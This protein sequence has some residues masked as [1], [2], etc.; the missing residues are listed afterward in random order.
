M[1]V[2]VL[3]GNGYCERISALDLRV[4]SRLAFRITPRISAALRFSVQGRG[5]P[6]A[7]RAGR[8]HEGDLLGSQPVTGPA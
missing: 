6:S 2:L 4:G 8:K 3:G 5:R 7:D 1:N